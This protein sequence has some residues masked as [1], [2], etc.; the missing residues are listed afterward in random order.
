MKSWTGQSLRLKLTV[1]LTGIAAVTLLV[2]MIYSG[3]RSVKRFSISLVEQEEGVAKVLAYNLGPVVAFGNNREGEEMLQALGEQPHVLEGALLQTAPDGTVE[4]FAA[5]NPGASG[6]QMPALV[7]GRVFLPGAL[8]ITRPV[9]HLGEQLGWLQLVLSTRPLMD[10]IRAQVVSTLVLIVISSFVAY[11]LARRFIR[12][13]TEPIDDLSYIADRVVESHDY[14]YRAEG[15]G[16]AEMN[17]LSD[18]F[19]KMLD[20]IEQRDQELILAQSTLRVQVEELDQ[21]NQKLTETR[22]RELELKDQLERAKRLESLGLL[23]GGVA[24]D[25]NN[26][27]GPI[28]G[29]PDLLLDELPTDDPM[30]EDLE[31]VRDAAV[32]ASAIVQDLLALGRR[33][34]YQFV[35]TNLNEV[36]KGYLRSVGYLKL[37]QAHPHIKLQLN[38]HEGLWPI[39]GSTN[40]LEQVMMNL[41]IN[42]VEAMGETGSLSISTGNLSLK[43]EH[44]GFEAIPPGDYVLLSV[45]DDGCGIDPDLMERIFEPF[46]SGK[47]LGSS[48]SGL[49]LAVVYGVVKDHQAL[50]D[51]KSMPNQGTRFKVFFPRSCDEV[52]EVESPAAVMKG[53]EHILIVDDEPAQRRLTSRLLRQLGYRTSTVGSGTDAVAFVKKSAPDM[54]LMD[55]I[56]EENFDGL[57]AMRE[58]FETHPE[59]KCM[60]ISGY[61][62]NKR[63]QEA[64]ELGACDFISKP[65]SRAELG[66]A[67][68]A[69]LHPKSEDDAE[70]ASSD[71]GS[72]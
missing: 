41:V 59:Q 2:S 13:V 4:P 29:Y 11:F 20:G 69:H 37:K 44:D 43:C 9:M 39:D 42:A 36:L 21:K 32:K 1:V 49:G 34:N 27:L 16:Q 72:W 67:L 18:A 17:A 38:L 15:S 45:A 25:L 23:A 53:C 10:E 24:H 6:Q 40:H 58:I 48:G 65:Y 14:T 33:G 71:T 51:I 12:A 30:R 63:I 55:M 60:M 28:V 5:Y 26:M 54:I 31:Q 56:M 68:R 62:D 50:L 61:S 46:F 70:H 35:A 19:N 52:A 7:A 8:V 3:V 22:K 66:N 64:L 57:D 47:T